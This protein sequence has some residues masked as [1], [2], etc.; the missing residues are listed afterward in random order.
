MIPSTAPTSRSRAQPLDGAAGPCLLI[1]VARVV[2]PE[3]RSI[4]AATIAAASGSSDTNAGCAPITALAAASGVGQGE[5]TQ[6]HQCVGLGMH[7]GG[8]GGET[9]VIICCQ[10]APLALLAP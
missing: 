10:V 7:G 9:A 6:L 8:G 1:E 5:A 2:N 4:V 3:A